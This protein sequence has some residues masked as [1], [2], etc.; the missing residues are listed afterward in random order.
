M[1]ERG[2]SQEGLKILA[3]LTMLA[4]HAGMVLFPRQMGFRMIGRL[5]FPIFCFLL[6]EGAHY[7]KNPARYALRL[8]VGAL[9]SELPFDLACSGG[10]DW[11]SQS[12]ML[13]LLIGFLMLVC[14][15]RTESLPLRVLM[16]IPFAAL[17]EACQTDYGASGIVLIGI[18]ALTRR[19]ASWLRTLLVFAGLL[20][21]PSIR[22]T[23][24]GVRFPMELLGIFAMVP[25]LFYSGKKRSY[26][27]PLQWAFYLFYP[28]HL[29][30]LWLIK[31][32]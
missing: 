29:T 31:V 12:V 1:K 19:A 27:K 14:M 17:A 3:C 6:T 21:V 2:I 22:I 11:E 4:D 5:A 16:V 26:S 23:V 18:F 8:A 30:L 13:T 20:L 28:V 7:T 9:L 25:I 10:W 15:K 24:L 32:L